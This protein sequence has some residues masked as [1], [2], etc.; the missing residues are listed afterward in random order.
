MPPDSLPA[1]RRGPGRFLL[2]RVV[3]KFKRGCRE[4][5]GSTREGVAATHQVWTLGLG[6]GANRKPS[7]NHAKQGRRRPP[8]SRIAEARIFTIRRRRIA[9]AR[10]FTIR[11]RQSPTGLYSP[12]TFFVLYTFVF[13]GGQG[14]TRARGSRA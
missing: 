1:L 2:S 9:E 14:G 5:H 3:I 6:F 8:A 13:T 12:S 7:P 10:I 4:C 11:R